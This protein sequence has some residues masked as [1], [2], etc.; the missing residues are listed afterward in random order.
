M[1]NQYVFV[2]GLGERYSNTTLSGSTIPTTEPDKK[3]VPLDLFPTGLIDSVQIAKSY[4]ADK[5]ADFAGGLVQIVPLKFPSRPTFD[6]SWG[7]RLLERHRKG[8]HPESARQSRLLGF[9]DGARA[10]PAIFPDSK[11]VRSGIYTPDV[12]F[13]PDEITTFGHALEDV[14]RPGRG[15]GAPG[16]T[17]ASSLATGSVSSA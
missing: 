13:A 8:H 1:D 2:R 6:L 12:G 14:W 17:S 4:S 5:S 16:R 15:R 7:M 3:V 10:M 11:I 9:D